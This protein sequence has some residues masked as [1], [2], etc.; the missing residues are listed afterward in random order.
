MYGAGPR[1]IL[2]LRPFLSEVFGEEVVN[3]HICKEAVIRVS[4]HHH[5]TLYVRLTVL[6]VH[7]SRVSG[8]AVDTVRSNCISTALQ[9]LP[10][11]GQ[12]FP[13]FETTCQYIAISSAGLSIL[14]LGL[15][16]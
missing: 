3:C 6:S 9:S 11:Q 5:N 15:D 7:M 4:D 14:C 10:E 12:L 1:F 8:V 2:E 13:R 16:Q